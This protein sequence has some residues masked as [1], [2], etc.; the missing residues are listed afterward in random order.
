VHK[1]GNCF[2]P[3]CFFARKPSLGWPPLGCTTALIYILTTG[4]V[5][6]YLVSYLVGYPGNELPYLI[7]AALTTRNR[8]VKS[9][10]ISPESLLL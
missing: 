3:S 7:T 6:G 4:R 2:Y 8:G 1:P 10:E 5:L 9:R